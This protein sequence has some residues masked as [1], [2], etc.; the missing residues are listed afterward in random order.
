MTVDLLLDESRIK[1]SLTDP[2]FPSYVSR[3]LTSQFIPPLEVLGR[4]V[5]VIVFLEPSQ[6]IV[7]YPLLRI[8]SQAIGV[9]KPS[10]PPNAAEIGLLWE[11]EQ[12]L[13]ML[14]GEDVLEQEEQPDYVL[15]IEAL[16][17]WTRLLKSQSIRPLFKAEQDK[18]T[19]MLFGDLANWR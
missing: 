15:R 19:G 6:G 18:K 17:A 9:W 3:A 4:L 8:I 7:R 2:L 5:K 16:E 11:V 14:V 10:T 1:A 12:L 13:R